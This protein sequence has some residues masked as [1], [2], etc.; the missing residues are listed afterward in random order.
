MS[1]GIA[2]KWKYLQQRRLIGFIQYRRLRTTEQRQQLER[3]RFQYR[4]LRASE[5]AN[6]R[7]IAH[8]QLVKRIFLHRDQLSTTRSQA[9]KQIGEG[10]E[11]LD[12]ESVSS[13]LM[14]HQWSMPLE[15]AR[16]EGMDSSSWQR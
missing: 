6:P 10:S 2:Q 14:I 8:L 1:K 7:K 4:I 11:E 3:N 12:E 16:N 13:F 15:S 9:G 5:T